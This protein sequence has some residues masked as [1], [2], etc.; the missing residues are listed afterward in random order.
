[1]VSVVDWRQ[2][3]HIPGD[4]SALART[5]QRRAQ[6]GELE[7]VAPGVYVLAGTADEVASRVRRHWQRIASHLV[8]GAVVSYLSAFRGG[9]LPDGSVTLSHP[10]RYNRTIEM[11]GVSLVL[12]KGPSALPGDTTMRDTGL[13]WA[14]THRT[15]LENMGRVMAKRPTRA[16]KAAVE[17]RIV[18]MLHNQGVESLNRLRDAARA[19]ATPLG[20]QKQ[21][22]E[23]CGIVSLLLKTHDKA[24]PGHLRT[25]QGKMSASGVPMDVERIE[26]LQILA[27]ALRST[28]LP[29]LRDIAASGAA[30]VH[31]AFIESYFSN[32]VEG[33]KFS[34]EEAQEIVLH[35][36][37]MSNRP[38][39]SHDVLGVFAQAT[40]MGLR[41]SVPPPGAAFVE[42]LE[43]RHRLLMQ[44]RPETNPGQIKTRSN[45]VGNTQ[46][47]LPQ[48]VRGTLQEGSALALG[49]PEGLHRAIY[50]AFL[51]SEVHP[52]DDGNGRL[53]RLLMNAEL[54]RVGL[55]RVII[56]T[57]YHPQYVDCQRALTRGNDPQGFIRSIDH[58][59][60]WCAGFDYSDLQ[61]LIAHLHAANAFEENPAEH[62]LL[63]GPDSV[64]LLRADRAI[65][66]V[67]GASVKTKGPEDSK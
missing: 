3:L 60:R 12:L 15:L 38:K 46:F 55:C 54:S 61:Q 65:A 7:R 29:E 53:S 17:E 45:F 36:A 66:V 10:T 8:P 39:D 5:A 47:V 33:T 67:R 64:A 30:K 49:V 51:L 44:R 18:F 57:L 28:P 6:A 21:C 56:P 59:A 52:F 14:S 42:G 50:Y 13:Y 26:R 9:L 32:Y 24:H 40:E 22:D 23:L 62:K 48:F 25:Q 34:I 58:A 4:D 2:E 43:K 37:P 20:M 63:F 16:G 27:N 41:D 35:N 31:F 1:M 19:V 11:P